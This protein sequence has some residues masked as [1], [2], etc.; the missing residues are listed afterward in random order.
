MYPKLWVNL[1]VD[2]EIVST[3][4][5]KQQ[6]KRYFSQLSER[7]TDFM[8]GQSNQDQQIKSRGNR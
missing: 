2:V 5:K 6:N 3:K 8:I 4:N 7:D 1:I